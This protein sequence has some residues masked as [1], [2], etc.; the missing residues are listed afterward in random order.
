MVCFRTV[1]WF[2]VLHTDI[3][4]SMWPRFSTSPYNPRIQPPCFYLFE[5][6]SV[7]VQSIF[8]YQFSRCFFFYISVIRIF[9]ILRWFTSKYSYSVPS[10]VGSVG[11]KHCA[12]DSTVCSLFFN[13]LNTNQDINSRLKPKSQVMNRHRMET[14]KRLMMISTCAGSWAA[15]MWANRQKDTDCVTSNWKAAR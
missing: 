6:S 7:F 5:N 12:S 1:W 15:H 4:R 3:R 9:N 14:Q 8:W 2:S 10:T 11:S 13:K